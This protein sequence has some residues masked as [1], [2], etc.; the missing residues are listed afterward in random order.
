M[1]ASSNLG[2]HN[3]LFWLLLRDRLNTRNLLRRKN[4]ELENYNGVL[5]NYDC[6]ETNLHLFFECPFS[7]ACWNT[8]PIC[9]N[10]N[11]PPLDMVIDAST[12]FG[13]PIFRE[14]FIMACWIIWVTRNVVIFDNGQINLNN[15]RRQFREELDLVCTKA[16]PSRQAA[17]INWKENYT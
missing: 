17:L 3:F 10:T 8:I 4:M 15:W 11:M 5:C 1:W 14:I 16:K 13:S 6:E 12:S 7:I 9:W 2:K